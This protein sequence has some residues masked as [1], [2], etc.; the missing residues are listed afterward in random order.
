MAMLDASSEVALASTVPW[1]TMTAPTVTSARDDAAPDAVTAVEESTTIVREKPW[2]SVITTVS[3]LR[4]VTVPTSVTGITLTLVA[5]VVSLD[6]VAT[7][8]CSPTMT[9]DESIVVGPSAKV[10]AEVMA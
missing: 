4:E 9:W 7:A 2:E 8:T 10:V 3:A 6:D 1:A 5:V